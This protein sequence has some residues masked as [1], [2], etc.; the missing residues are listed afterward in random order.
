MA[1]K[2][3]LKDELLQAREQSVES[4]ER[5]FCL[6]GL[7]HGGEIAKAA[8]LLRAG[9]VCGFEM[10][11]TATLERLLGSV[12]QEHMEGVKVKMAGW[13]MRSAEQRAS[14]AQK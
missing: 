4:L 14:V 12:F 6:E 8:F 9:N 2:Y 11:A 1:A 7:N 5:L 3:E 13:S 10:T